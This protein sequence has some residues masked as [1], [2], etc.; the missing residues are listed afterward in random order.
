[1]DV[2]S[3]DLGAVRVRPLRSPFEG[4]MRADMSSGSPSHQT[5]FWIR[6]CH[7]RLLSALFASHAGHFTGRDGLITAQLGLVS[8]DQNRTGCSSDHGF[9][10]AAEDQAG[11][12]SEVVAAKDDQVSLPFFARGDN[13]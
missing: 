13:F 12:T 2:C 7:G 6:G 8:H 5:I 9:G 11:E 3:S 1:S 4:A 10:G